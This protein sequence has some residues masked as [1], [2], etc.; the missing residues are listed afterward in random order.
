MGEKRAREIS[1]CEDA[2]EPREN[3]RAR[4]EPREDFV[5]FGRE[6]GEDCEDAGGQKCEA[7]LRA[8]TREN[9]AR[10][11]VRGGLRARNPPAP[12]REDRARKARPEI[13][14]KQ[15]VREPHED[16]G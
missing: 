2:R 9:R 5:H 8:R 7:I 12:T 16:A 10:A 4:G 14:R 3:T 6:T 11:H 1:R 13:P 15:S